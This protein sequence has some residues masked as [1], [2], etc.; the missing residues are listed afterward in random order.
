VKLTDEVQ[1]SG[2]KFDGT[3]LYSSGSRVGAVRGSS[4]YERGSRIGELRGNN[5]YSHGSRIGELRGNVIYSHGSRV[6]T[7]TDARKA[8]DG[9]GG[10]TLA[11]LW[12]LLV[13]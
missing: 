10:A 2:Y 4:I 7:L 6:G 11:A 1:M 3:N 9:S 5:I 12:L 8:I 13:K